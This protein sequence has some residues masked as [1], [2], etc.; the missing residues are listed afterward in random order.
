[1][2]IYLDD[3]E[4]DERLIKMEIFLQQKAFSDV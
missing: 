3:G 4:K 1:M 2:V